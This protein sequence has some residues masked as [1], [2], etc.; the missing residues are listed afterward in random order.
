VQ[1]YKDG[2]TGAPFSVHTAAERE[3][4][5]AAINPNPDKPRPLEAPIELYPYAVYESFLGGGTC[6]GGGGDGAA[7]VNSKLQVVGEVNGCLVINVPKDNGGD[8]EMFYGGP[9]WTP[10]ASHKFSPFAEVLVGARRIT[11]DITDVAKKKELT[12]EWEHGELKHDFLRSDYQVEYQSMGFAMKVG[13]G[14]DEVFAR[15]FAWRVLDVGYTRSWVNAVDP[16][17]A[18]RSVS[19]ASGLVLRIGTW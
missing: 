14:F 6:I 11:H 19:I 13:G 12:Y 3:A 9:R 15:S 7:R 5:N 16:I 1:D 4:M 18:Q 10:R 17:N 2:K 8:S